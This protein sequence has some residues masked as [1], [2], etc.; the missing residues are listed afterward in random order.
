MH[1]YFAEGL[2]LCPPMLHG[3]VP[4]ICQPGVN[5]YLMH[6]QGGVQ[7]GKELAIQPH[8]AI[9]QDCRCVS[10]LEGAHEIF[11]HKIQL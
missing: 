9:A 1:N 5:G 6:S 4:S 10:L 7:R 3:L 2:V 8:S 11:V